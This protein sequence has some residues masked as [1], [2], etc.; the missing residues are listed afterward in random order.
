MS[1]QVYED[2]FKYFNMRRALFPERRK[3]VMIGMVANYIVHTK[4]FNCKV[5]SVFGIWEPQFWDVPK[6]QLRSLHSGVRN[7]TKPAIQ[8]H[9]DLSS[10]N[11][12]QITASGCVVSN[13]N[14]GVAHG[15]RRKQ[16][17]LDMDVESTCRILARGFWGPDKEVALAGLGLGFYPSYD[18]KVLQN[19]SNV[20]MAYSFFKWVGIH[21]GS[22]HSFRAC[23]V[24]ISML[25]NARRFT[26]AEKV[27]F[28][29]QNSRVRLLPRIFIE[30][31]RSYA[32]AGLLEKSVEA[33]KRMEDHGFVLSAPAYNSLI[34][35]FV[36][37]GYHQKALAVYRVMG[38]SGLRPD[39]YTFNVLMNAFKKAK[40]IDSVCKLFK[41]MQNQ[42]CTP[43][44]VTFSTLI[45]ALCKSGDVGEAVNVFAD[46]KAR[47]CKPNVFTYTSMIDG[48]GKAGQVDQA[49]F[50]FE[51]MTAAGLVANR[52]VYNS[53]IHGL[54]RIGRADAAGKLF[55][56]MGSKR[57]QPDY[58]TFTSLVY[59]LG[60][61]GRAS[62]ARRLFE[63]ARNVG[64][65]LDTSLYNAL[66]DTL[67]KAKR[68]DEAWEIF[69]GLEGKLLK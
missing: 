67:C 49:F 51:E 19:L 27:L 8:E 11:S 3:V 47:G 41:E 53:L 59:G 26:E 63:E 44:V 43:N 10:E 52:V 55:R 6:E 62:E 9:E 16:Q 39:T 24:L 54:G 61:A 23:N 17:S 29:V 15:V 32:S 4:H 58:V 64:C 14:L 37:A 69:G 65:A 33:L 36:K 38:Q 42:D 2:L 21:Q 7:E 18:W 1:N 45:D 31:A 50:L 35:A 68:L 66:I 56:E 30:L 20:D 22:P 28:E 34:D 48:L 40:K 12:S 57:L 60:V 5:A 25:G 46:M 13:P